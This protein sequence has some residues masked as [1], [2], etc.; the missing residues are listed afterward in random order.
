MKRSAAGLLAFAVTLSPVARAAGRS[1]RI[2]CNLGVF[3]KA[4]RA[5]HR[6]LIVVLKDKVGEMRE[7]PGGYAF[8]YP[9]ELLG[10]LAEWTALESKCCPFIDFQ[11]EL[12]PQPSGSAWLRLLGDDE[13]KEFI[14]TDFKPLIQFAQEKGQQR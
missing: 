3:T 1:E 11:L 6:E 12:E 2:F 4:E 14:R 7:V 8:R 9:P 13:V 5:R 10:Q